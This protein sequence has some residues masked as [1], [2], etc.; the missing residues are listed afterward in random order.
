[1]YYYS[2]IDFVTVF[3]TCLLLVYYFVAKI[4]KQITST[5]RFVSF[6]GG[7]RGSPGPWGPF[8]ESAR[9]STGRFEKVREGSRRF[10]KVGESLGKLENVQKARENSRKLEKVREG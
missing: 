4:L 2:F 10:E 5:Y 1:M 3:T 8:S 6:P 7:L 9:S